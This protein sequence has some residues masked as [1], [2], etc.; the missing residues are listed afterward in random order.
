MSSHPRLTGLLMLPVLLPSAMAQAQTQTPNPSPVIIHAVAPSGPQVAMALEVKG[1]AENRLVFSSLRS[2]V[3]IQTITLKDPAQHLVWRKTPKE[4]GW[5]PASVA[6]H[7]ELGDAIALPEIRNAATGKWLL[8]LQRSAPHG[9]PG[10]LQLSYSVLPRFDLTMT[11]SARRVAAGQPLLVTLRPSDYGA[12]MPGLPDILIQLI[13]PADQALLDSTPAREGLRSPSGILVS[14]EPG[15]YMANLSVSQAG[16]VRLLASLRFQG[17]QA[18]SRTAS[19]DLLVEAAA[20]ALALTDITTNR[21]AGHT[22]T[23][24]ATFNFS[25]TVAKPGTYVCNMSLRGSHGTSRMLSASAELPAGTTRMSI[26]AGASV[27]QSLGL[28]LAQIDKVTLLN[29]AP[30]GIQAVATLDAITL[31]GHA[32]NASPLCP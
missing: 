31:S 2:T 23:R 26:P 27:L 14:T 10:Q 19:A 32:I 6:T 25:V 12:P 3:G 8:E 28:P 24:S 15:V 4:L 18:V 17:K 7:P 9:Q 20:G 30:A 1:E 11:M 16:P 22:C 21:E 5:T 29:F 13:R